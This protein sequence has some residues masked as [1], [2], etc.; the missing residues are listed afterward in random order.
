[1]P[2]GFKLLQIE[3]SIC[4]LQID[5]FWIFPVSQ[6]FLWGY[7]GVCNA[8]LGIDNINKNVTY[9]VYRRDQHVHLCPQMKQVW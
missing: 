4:K 9:K 7:H 3:V 5:S 1:M 6:S 8:D 2:K